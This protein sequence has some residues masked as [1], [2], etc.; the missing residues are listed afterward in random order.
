V[1]SVSYYFAF[2]LHESLS[3]INFGVIKVKSTSVLYSSGLHYVACIDPWYE[4]Y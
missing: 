3:L 4:S 1:G 2:C